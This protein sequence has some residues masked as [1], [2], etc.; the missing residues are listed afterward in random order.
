MICNLKVKHFGKTEVTKIKV[1]DKNT[2]ETKKISQFIGKSVT[3]EI[4]A[5][6]APKIARNYKYTVLQQNNRSIMQAAIFF[7]RV[8]SRTP[9][10]EHYYDKDGK[11]GHKPD[12]DYIWKSWEV[13]YWGKTLSAAN[14]DR[15]FFEEFDDKSSI[16]KIYHMLRELYGGDDR[17]S[18][19]KTRIKNIRVE[20]KHPRFALLEYGDYKPA[21]SITIKGPGKEEG[22][23]HGKQR[24][25]SVQAPY[26]MERITLAEMAQMDDKVIDSYFKSYETYKDDEFYMVPSA[27]Q[28]KELG[29][30]LG[31]NKI[32]RKHLSKRYIEKIAE[33]MER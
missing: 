17:L 16:F 8:V 1:T 9:I 4:I 19:R 30:I 14:I 20:N 33:V 24:G 7:Q 13:K 26:G 5:G 22:R 27:E 29:K 10:D 23:M 25:Y 12:K 6:V 2:G 3:E 21:D 18:A 28:V 31:K 32:T 11:R 15:S